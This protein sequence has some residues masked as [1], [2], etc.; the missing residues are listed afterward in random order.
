MADTERQALLQTIEKDESSGLLSVTS[1]YWIV[2]C[3]YKL[4]AKYTNMKSPQ[5]TLVKMSSTEFSNALRKYVSKATDLF[6][7]AAVDTYDRDDY[8]SFKST[9]RSSKFLQKME[10]KLNARVART[11]EKALPDLVAVAKSAKA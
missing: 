4:I 8:G 2:Y 11:A 9:L 7:D 1:S 10:G 3:C 5:V 6:Y